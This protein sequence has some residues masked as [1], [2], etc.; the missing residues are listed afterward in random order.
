MIYGFRDC[1]Y[2]S[3]SYK[4]ACKGSS[5]I[6]TSS[7]RE[8]VFNKQIDRADMKRVDTVRLDKDGKVIDFS[9]G[10]K[11]SIKKLGRRITFLPNQS[12]PTTLLFFLFVHIMGMVNKLPGYSVQLTYSK[13]VEEEG[14]AK[15]DDKLLLVPKDMGRR[16]SRTASSKLFTYIDKTKVCIF[17]KCIIAE[18]LC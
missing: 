8:G 13:L 4:F 1:L 15:V 5:C 2:N 18:I 17:I 14:R 7:T 9:S 6:Y 16:S 3:Y 11:K 12:L 10:N